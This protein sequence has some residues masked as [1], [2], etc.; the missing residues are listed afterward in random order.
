VSASLPCFAVQ[1]AHRVHDMVLH[2]PVGVVADVG[3]LHLG[4]GCQ[5][6]HVAPCPQGSVARE[7]RAGRR[8]E[9]H[10][11]LG[12]GHGERVPRDGSS[13]AT[14]SK[15]A[16]PTTSRS[17]RRSIS[18]KSSLSSGTSLMPDQARSRCAF[19]DCIPSSNTGSIARGQVVGRDLG[20]PGD[21]RAVLRVI[22]RH[23]AWWWWSTG[24]GSSVIS[25][26]SRRLASS[27]L[28]IRS[29]STPPPSVVHLRTPPWNDD[30]P[31]PA[32][33]GDG[34]DITDRWGQVVGSG[35]APSSRWRRRWRPRSPRLVAPH[36]A[37]A[38]RSSSTRMSKAWRTPASPAAARP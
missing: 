35:L 26:S 19:R 24:I 5:Q 23:P 21:L 33:R 16:T 13:N 29:R 27:R 7:V 20:D 6:C 37:M 18:A 2:R 9:R 4:V 10:R 1:R 32:A 14:H 28:K 30:W 17:K 3:Q 38:V 25:Y 34:A 36:S 8:H 12:E 22:D 15:S 31:R 11:R